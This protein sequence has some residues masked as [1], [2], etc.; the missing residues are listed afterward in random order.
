MESQAEQADGDRHATGP[1]ARDQDGPFALPPLIKFRQP[2]RESL[3]DHCRADHLVADRDRD[4]VA[5]KVE[6]AVAADLEAVEERV[7]GTP[8]TFG[9]GAWRS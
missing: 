7:H 5:R 3:D 6:D 9:V 1:R 2:D 4:Q 8:P